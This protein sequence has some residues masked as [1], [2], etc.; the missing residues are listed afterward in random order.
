MIYLTHDL[1]ELDNLLID[2]INSEYSNVYIFDTI[3][4]N[5]NIFW[6]EYYLILQ[7]YYLSKKIADE[8]NI[9]LTQ[10]EYNPNLVKRLYKF[11]GDM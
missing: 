3:D 8:K 6:K 2:S 11:K 1:K 9:D 10:P 5:E 4:L 7:M